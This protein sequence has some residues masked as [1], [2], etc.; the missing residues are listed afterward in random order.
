MSRSTARTR[1]D[2]RPKVDH[3]AAARTARRAAR[4][5]IESDL[6]LAVELAIRHNDADYI[7]WK[8]DGR[9]TYAQAFDR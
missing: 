6:E 4:R 9:V 1:S 8:T 5:S 7:E 2:D 3:R